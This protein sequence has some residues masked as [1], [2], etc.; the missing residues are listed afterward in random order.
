MSNLISALQG[1]NIDPTQLGALFDV[2]GCLVEPNKH[3]LTQQQQNT[4]AR[5]YSLTGGSIALFSDNDMRL[6]HPM[7]PFLP[8]ISEGGAVT[9][10]DNSRDINDAKIIAPKANISAMVAFAKSAVTA[11][12][13]DCFTT[14]TPSN[15]A[16]K[17][18]IVV[19]TKQ[20][21]MGLN[22]GGESP[23]LKE[24]AKEIGRLAIKEQGLCSQFNA[25]AESYDCVEITPVGFIKPDRVQ[26][27]AK[28]PRFRGLKTIMF[29]DSPIDSE[30]G[31]KIDGCVALDN[32][33]QTGQ[34]HIITHMTAPDELWHNLSLLCDYLEAHTHINRGRAQLALAA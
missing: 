26:D 18:R 27:I 33:I 31:K 12:G 11:Q 13:I 5:L 24:I 32:R 25:V 7:A 15:I 30:A 19:E 9:L 28:H 10:L 16:D 2:D 1:R 14:H 4:A 8:I 34:D 21:R 23:E 29:G 3:E 6:L 20:T 17:N 22:W